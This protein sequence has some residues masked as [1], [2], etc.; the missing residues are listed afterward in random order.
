MTK[1]KESRDG[2]QLRKHH[3]TRNKPALVNHAPQATHHHVCMDED[4]KK[5]SLKVS[6]LQYPS[7]L[8][9]DI[10]TAGVA[11]LGHGAGFCPIQNHVASE[12]ENKD[13]TRR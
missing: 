4:G 10:L 7:L 12:K 1:D 13:R 8:L 9:P 5:R 3:P 6:Q 2:P 11:F